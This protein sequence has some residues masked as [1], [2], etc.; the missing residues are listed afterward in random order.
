MC[1]SD[2]PAIAVSMRPTTASTL[3]QQGEPHFEG[4][5][6]PKCPLLWEW[7]KKKKRFSFTV[8]FFNHSRKMDII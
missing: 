3:P 8:G 6:Q 4:A 1:A 7:L 2:S 5:C